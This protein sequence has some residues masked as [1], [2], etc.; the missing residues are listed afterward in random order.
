MILMSMSGLSD[1]SHLTFSM[2]CTTSMPW[3]T[4]PKTVCLLSSHAHGAVVMKNCE[5][6]FGFGFEGLRAVGVGPRVGHRDGEGAVVAERA[7][8]LVLELVPPDRGAAGAVAERVARLHH[9]AL[10]HSMEDDAVIVAVARVRRKVLNGLRALVS[11]EFHLNQG[12]RQRR[13][14]IA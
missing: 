9:E 1:L 5:P 12:H 2:P 6:G 11:E 10:D 14:C 13:H 4:R 3:K 7:V 8:E